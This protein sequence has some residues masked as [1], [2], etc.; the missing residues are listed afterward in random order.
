MTKEAQDEEKHHEGMTYNEVEKRAELK[1]TVINKNKLALLIAKL[2]I[3]IMQIKS[4][5][6]L[7]IAN[8]ILRVP[9]IP[10]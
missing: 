10:T 4:E 2:Y 6:V 9:F 7:L 1:E 8:I 5:E 3:K